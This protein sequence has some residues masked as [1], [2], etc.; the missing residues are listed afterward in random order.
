M[1]E[2]R[3]HCSHHARRDDLARL[4]FEV[5]YHTNRR[6]TSPRLSF[7]KEPIMSVDPA[8]AGVLPA[9]VRR[10]VAWRVVPLIFVLYVIAYLDRA[11]LAFA[12]LE[13][14]VDLY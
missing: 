8:L 10:K 4:S 2:I 9:A 14:Q 5:A 11:N 3:F 7:A 12:K 1:R 6:W 13:M